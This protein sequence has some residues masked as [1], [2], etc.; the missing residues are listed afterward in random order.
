[1]QEME[2]QQK[3][4]DIIKSGMQKRKLT[5]AE[6]LD[7]LKDKGIKKFKKDWQENQKG[8]CKWHTNGV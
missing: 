5:K 6:L 3:K 1:M 7:H 8:Y 2:H 4:Y